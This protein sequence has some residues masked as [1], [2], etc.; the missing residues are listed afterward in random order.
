MSPGRSRVEV[1]PT[2]EESPNIR[3]DRVELPNRSTTRS[4]VLRTIS[5][6]GNTVGALHRVRIPDEIVNGLTDTTIPRLAEDFIERRL[7]PRPADQTG[8][9]KMGK[10]RG[11]LD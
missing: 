1:H 2:N 10:V 9:H 11:R 4:R 5:P 3:R 8:P 7:A 6:T